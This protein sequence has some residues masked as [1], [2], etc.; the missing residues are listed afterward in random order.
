RLGERRTLAA[1]IVTIGV[2]LLL[3]VPLTGLTLFAVREAIDGVRFIRESLAQGGL[4]TLVAAL[5]A[6]IRAWA[7]RGLALLPTDLDQLSEHLVG[8]GQWAASAL[9]G[10][11]S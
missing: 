3:L 11:L 10:A 1:A 4:D 7:A 8:G 2:V 5:P 9:S 6:Q